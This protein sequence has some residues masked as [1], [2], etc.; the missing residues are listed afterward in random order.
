MP[1]PC[2]LKSKSEPLR[3]D[4]LFTFSRIEVVVDAMAKQPIETMILTEKTMGSTRSGRV[5]AYPDLIQTISIRVTN[6]SW[7]RM[8]HLRSC[9]KT[10]RRSAIFSLKWIPYN[11][12]LSQ[13]EG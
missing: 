6:I 8:E 5:N 2:L 1:I 9:E 11:R 10:K 12:H 3:N 7:L 13:T 4:L